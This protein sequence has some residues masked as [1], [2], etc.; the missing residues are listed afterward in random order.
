MKVTVE[1]DCTPAEA[2]EFLGLPDVR[3]MQAAMMSRMETR[4]QESLEK[5]S[6]DAMLKSWLPF[7]PKPMAGIPDLF[8]KFLSPSAAPTES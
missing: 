8:A 6:P 4:M 3:P 2:R 1:I 7:D 5:L